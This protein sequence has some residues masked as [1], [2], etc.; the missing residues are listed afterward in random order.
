MQTPVSV[1]LWR[2]GHWYLK[3]LKHKLT[4]CR[5]G[6]HLSTQQNELVTLQNLARKQQEVSTRYGKR[7]WKQTVH[8]SM[9]E[10]QQISSEDDAQ[11]VEL[12][13]KAKA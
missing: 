3:Q 7:L 2:G 10:L 9:D 6:A 11:N 12:F 1:P 5:C 8:Q 13:N 4:V